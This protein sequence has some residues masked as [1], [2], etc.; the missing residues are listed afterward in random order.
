MRIKRWMI[1]ERMLIPEHPEHLVRESERC[2]YS[3]QGEYPS[4][5]GRG[6]VWFCEGYSTL[7]L[8]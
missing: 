8:S 4:L 5:N 7:N 6:M 2:G 3:L 1:L